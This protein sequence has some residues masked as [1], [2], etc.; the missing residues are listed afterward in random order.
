M[1]T[2]YEKRN[3]ELGDC[4]QLGGQRNPYASTNAA[5]KMQ[6]TIQAAVATGMASIRDENVQ[7]L[8][9]REEG[10]QE[11]IN[12]LTAAMALIAKEQ[13]KFLKAVANKENTP[14][15]CKKCRYSTNSSNDSS[16]DDEPTPTLRPCKRNKKKTGKKEKKLEYKVGNEFKIGMKFHEN[17]PYKK[18][19]SS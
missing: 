2:H 11:Q 10:M 6:N 14:P 1:A 17:W 4:R 7:A 19:N 9:A 12:K 16:S 15:R 13:S 18:D 5:T 8:T 3:K